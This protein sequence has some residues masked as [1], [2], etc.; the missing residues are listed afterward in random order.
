MKRVVLISIALLAN[1]VCASQLEPEMQRQQSFGL[2]GVPDP[3]ALMRKSIEQLSPALLLYGDDLDPLKPKE[4]WIEFLV[5]RRNECPL[6]DHAEEETNY[7][8]IE[9]LVVL[10]A[11]DPVLLQRLLD[12]KKKRLLLFIQ[13]LKEQTAHET[14]VR[15]YKR[16]QQINDELSIMGRDLEDVSKEQ[17]IKVAQAEY[18]R[19]HDSSGNY[20]QWQRA[21]TT[22]LPL[23]IAYCEKEQEEIRMRINQLGGVAL[24]ELPKQPET[25]LAVVPQGVTRQQLLNAITN[26]KPRRKSFWDLLNI[27]KQ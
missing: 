27:K 21:R 14:V 16:V 20:Y 23:F 1:M 22:I 3:I 12:Y 10:E 25:Q 24:V 5:A 4:Q 7:G 17:D 19:S 18:V 8:E 9:N 2:Q 26:K 13:Q 15:R 11:T 6:V